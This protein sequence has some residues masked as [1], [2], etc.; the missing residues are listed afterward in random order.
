MECPANGGSGGGPVFRQE[1][2]GTA[3]IIGVMSRCARDGNPATGYCL[4]N[5]V[6]YFDSNFGALWSHYAAGGGVS[7]PTYAS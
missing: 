1:S 5:Y 3:D 6:P 4:T 7:V 2:D